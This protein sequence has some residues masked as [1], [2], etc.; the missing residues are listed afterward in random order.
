MLGKLLLLLVT[1]FSLDVALMKVTLPLA[2]FISM[3]LV[4]ASYAVPGVLQTY[5]IVV[6]TV[7]LVALLYLLWLF[8]RVYVQW[9]DFW[10]L[11]VTMV[12]LMA[13]IVYGKD[14]TLFVNE[15]LGRLGG[16]GIVGR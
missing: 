8:E 2:K 15:F 13:V 7:L 16:L 4:P 9:F 12:I 14:I 1:A 6:F 11:L 5:G 10:D 3:L